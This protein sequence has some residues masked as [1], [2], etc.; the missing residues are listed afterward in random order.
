[1]KRITFSTAV[2][3]LFVLAITVFLTSCFP[4]PDI[5]RTYTTAMG[6]YQTWGVTIQISKLARARSLASAPGFSSKGC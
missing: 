4:K 6:L 3:G 5:S 2:A 1:M